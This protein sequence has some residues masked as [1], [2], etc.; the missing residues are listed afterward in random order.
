MFTALLSFVFSGGKGTKLSILLL[1]AVLAV[2]GTYV[3][4]KTLEIR[5]L[6]NQITEL[7]AV[8]TK[9]TV[10][11]TMLIENNKVLKENQKI[12]YEANDVNQDTIKKL[13]EE[14]KQSKIAIANLAAANKRGNDALDQ[15]GKKIDELLLDPA[16]D[17][18]VAPVL[19][20]TIN[21]IQRQR[22]AK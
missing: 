3:G 17:G 13:M 2:I 12:L 16:N 7:H 9:L 22:G 6:N 20:E 14:R 10:D 1:V 15:L 18:T 4:L 11:N 5:N 19:R 8:N 21:Q